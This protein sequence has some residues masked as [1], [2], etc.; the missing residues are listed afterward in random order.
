M[1]ALGVI[2]GLFTANAILGVYGITIMVRKKI[3]VFTLDK[4]I[5]KRSLKYSLPILPHNLATPISSYSS[6][7]IINSSVS[8]ATTGLYT[9]ST[10]ISLILSL[11]QASINLAF[12]PWFN[13]QMENKNEGRMNIKIFTGIIFSVYVF[14]SIAVA[15]FCQEIIYLFTS[16]EYHEAWKIV[17]I[18]TAA[19]VVEFI[20]YIYVLTIMYDIWASKFTAICSISGAMSNIIISYLLVPSYKSYGAAI[21]FFLSKITISVIAVL[22]SKKIELVDFGLKQMLWKIVLSIV[23]IGAG[24]LFTILFNLKG[25]NWLNILYKVVLLI[26]IFFYLFWKM[27]KQIKEYINSIFIKKKFA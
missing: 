4:E 27:R 7:L 24:L 1:G 23:A 22:L 16:S 25:I 14:V 5:L 20:Y 26:S 13:E 3:M 17:P 10:Q 15:Y 12:R 18:L 11:V 19:L 21:A 6:K 8:Y 9:V 2:L